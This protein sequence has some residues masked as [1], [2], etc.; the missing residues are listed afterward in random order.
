MKLRNYK[1]AS[2]LTALAAMITPSL[3]ATVANPVNNDI[4]IAFRSTSASSSLIV[5]VGQ[6]SAFANQAA[7]SP[8]TTVSLGALGN[9]GADLVSAFGAN[10][11]TSGNVLWGAFGRST[12]GFTTVYGSREQTSVGTTGDAWP[13]LD[14]TA[15]TSTSSAIG[16]VLTGS[17]GYRGGTQTLNS[18]VSVL[19]SNSAQSSSYAFQVGTAGTTDFG[20]L[21][22]WDSI[23]GDFGGGTSGTALDLFKFYATD[24]TGLTNQ[25]TTPGFFTIDDLG[26][27]SFTSIPEPS[28][29]LLGAAG[30]FALLTKRRRQS[31]VG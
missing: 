21:S 9:I 3:A 11:N 10:W 24:G 6:Y 16:S 22:G 26:A 19:Q 25:V 13:V 18:T 12:S 4:F 20:S 5:N 28:A 1:L 29:A 27:L 23:E 15:R 31:F 30:M 8:G 14:D 17:G 7:N 2:G